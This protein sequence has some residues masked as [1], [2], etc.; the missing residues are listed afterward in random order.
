MN[1]AYY[2]RSI[3]YENRLHAKARER[4]EVILSFYR[5]N[6]EHEKQFPNVVTDVGLR[7][8]T[9]D[10]YCKG[11]NYDFIVEID[12]LSHFQKTR[13]Y[14][15]SIRN[16]AFAQMGVRTVRFNIHEIVGQ[17]SLSEKQILERIV[18]IG[19]YPILASQKNEKEVMM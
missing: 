15:D 2:R 9:A 10:I 6:V 13:Q 18:T 1:S 16:M 4:L 11:S 5:Y 17:D 8:Y 7:D 19:G 12:G 14:K 3:K